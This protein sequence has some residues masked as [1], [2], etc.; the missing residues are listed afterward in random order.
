MAG[1]V[2]ATPMPQAVHAA[3]GWWVNRQTWAAE[4]CFSVQLVFLPPSFPCSSGWQMGPQ[5]Q[6]ALVTSVRDPGRAA[7]AAGA[8]LVPPGTDKGEEGEDSGNSRTWQ[9]GLHLAPA[10]L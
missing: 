1:P 9:L 2:L 10:R 4:T 7:S 8:V 5:G 3:M 6:V